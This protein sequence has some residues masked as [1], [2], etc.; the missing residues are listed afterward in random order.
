[1][2]LDSL[3]VVVALLA[4]AGLGFVSGTPLFEAIP[5]SRLTYLTFLTLPLLLLYAVLRRRYSRLAR[6]LGDWWQVLGVLGV[7]ESLKHMHANRITEWLG[8]APLDPLMIRIDRFLFGDVLPL[9]IQWLSVSWFTEIMWVF[10]VWVY[11]LGPV[12]LLG[13]AY[14]FL[15]DDSLFYRLR[16]AL[17]YGLLGG[18]VGYLLFP[19]A[20]PLFYV[21]DQFLKPILTQ[22]VLQNLV[23]STLRYNWDCFPSLHTAIPWLLTLAAWYRLPALGRSLAVVAAS[24][25]TLSTVVLRF[26]YGIDL[27]A[28]VVW[29]LFVFALVR[30]APLRR[31]TPKRSSSTTPMPT[32]IRSNLRLRLVLLAVLFVATGCAGLLAEQSFEKLLIPLVG[33]STPAGAVV[34]SVYFLGLTLGAASYGRL[35]GKR[36][37]PLRLYA[38]LEG[39]VA[40]W[41]LLLYV[42]FE[43][44]VTI[45]LPLLRLLSGSLLTLQFGRFL[46]ACC[47]I[48]PP[49]FL[50]GATFPAI[51]EALEGWRVPQAGRMMSRFYTLNLAGAVL[52]ALLGPYLAFPRWGIDGTLL[53]TFTID[54]IVALAAIR[55]GLTFRLRRRSQQP[56]TTDGSGT[57]RYSKSAW[58]IIVIGG[59]SGF[60]F[61]S[62]EVLWIH[63]FSAAVGNSV[64]AFAAMLALVLIGLLIGGLIAS[65]LLPREKTIPSVLLGGIYILS[66]LILYWAFNRWDTL[67]HSFSIWGAGLFTFAQGELLRWIQAGIQMLPAA[68]CLGMVYPLLFRVKGFP[69]VGRARFAGILSAANSVGCISGALLTSFFLIP[70]LGSETTYAGIGVLVLLMG[71]AISLPFTRR[72]TRITSMVTATL[73]LVTWLVTPSWDRL[74]LTSG[75]NVYFRMNQV[76]PQSEL[77]S[78]HEDT[79]GGMTTVV[80]NPPGVRGQERPYLTLLTNGKFQGN[81]AWERDAQIGFALIP[82]LHSTHFDDACVIGLGSG[83]SA[84][85]VEA[86]GFGSIDIAEIAPGIVEAAR[87]HFAHVNDRILEKPHA[88][89][90]L[91]DGRNLLLLRPDRLYD[92]ITMEVSSVWFA[93]ST[94]LY[95]HEFYELIRARLKPEGVFQQWIQLHHIGANEVGSVLA[96]LRQVFP[97]VEFWVFGG[98]GILVASE[99]PLRLSPLA[100]AR[101]REAA[102]PRIGIPEALVSGYLQRVLESRLLAADDTSQLVRRVRLRVNTDRNRF[103]EY[104]TPKYN[105][106]RLNHVEMNLR[107]LSS[108]SSFARLE[109]DTEATGVPGEILEVVENA[110][111]RRTFTSILANGEE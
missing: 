28:G 11:Y 76:W 19:V 30:R 53:F 59:L 14:F 70:M 105:L 34:L 93:G 2:R 103:L 39:G 43:F 31:E 48:L 5:S 51:V 92:L 17:V 23:F 102:V 40:L 98:Q 87:D 91:E 79:Y 33:A 62:L 90:F 108:F 86:M 21:G 74:A 12:V 44:L 110:D 111:P 6:V 10:Y 32:M 9:Q 99:S 83:Q 7:Y 104:S 22:P 60:S 72:L 24:G 58:L 18:Y 64:Y 54:A 55:L 96:T 20:G 49:T 67:P 88:H 95:S 81:D 35:F 69:E 25:I 106:S 97:F 100:L 101:Y 29:A 73:I 63:L 4:L 80:R 13:W 38:F 26:H 15:E 71:L 57:G 41:A 36:S 46:V 84:H 52:G 66:S 8:I 61:F 65:N 82:L 68:I 16:S 85:V 107:A 27:L 94:S 78:F 37:N 42:G 77:V 3:L 89:L 1:M 47:W 109:L 75:E 45:F 56:V 50:M